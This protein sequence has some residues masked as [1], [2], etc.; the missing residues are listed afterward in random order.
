[1]KLQVH[2]VDFVALPMRTRFPFRYGIASLSDLPHV[3]VVATVETDT[4]IGKGISADGLPPKWF[5]KNPATKF[6]EDDVPQ[7]RRVIKH[8]ADVG[9]GLGEQPSPFRWW[10]ELYQSQQSW[11][12]ENDL[13]PL[14]ASLGA[15]LME[16]AVWDAISRL[17]SK[18]L[19]QL[20][21][22]NAFA[23]RL[24]EMRSSLEGLE[25]R[26]A[27][28]SKPL[29]RL[30]VRHTVGLGDPITAEDIPP[31]EALN[32]GLPHTLEEN[33]VRYG[34]KYFKV[35]IS[36]DLQRDLPRLEKIASLVNHHLGD[37]ARFSLDGNEQFATVG[38]LRSGWD[39][40][41][42]N[43]TIREF[44]KRSLLFVEQPL[45]RDHALSEGVREEVAQWIDRPPLII[46]ESD[47]DLDS[48]ERAIDL[49]Y[50]GTS[51]KN[52]KG[53]LKGVMNA[54]TVA[55]SKN[56]EKP[57]ILSAEDLGNV[58]PV[59]LL[60]D[61]AVVAMLGIEHAERNGHHYFQG[62]SMFDDSVQQLV[63]SDHGDL[64]RQHEFGFACLNPVEGTLTIDS[65][66]RAPFGISEIPRIGHLE[67][68]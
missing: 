41:C 34:L 46:D 15:S 58:G 20:I 63:L 31:G 28:P 55:Q 17:E 68:W 29:D 7:M 2:Q 33:I 43:S 44:I 57:L 40:L 13:P 23:I 36:G 21:R 67:P 42:R 25:P 60:Q 16:R 24:G 52:C 1:M 10:W 64:Y 5:T 45:H 12:S 47:G 30:Y 49:G 9:V 19:S 48:F 66:N 3:F 4:G 51:H 11:A 14:L 38:Q 54:A 50:C 65:V 18:P 35:K 53:V 27:L 22:S 37:A 32:D 62:L 39:S 6:E 8:A 61:I 56:A 59:A 26:D